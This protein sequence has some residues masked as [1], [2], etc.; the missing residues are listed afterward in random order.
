MSIVVSTFEISRKRTGFHTIKVMSKLRNS[1]KLNR[2]YF[3]SLNKFKSSLLNHRIKLKSGSHIV[4]IVVI[5]GIAN[6]FR[7][8]VKGI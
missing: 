1:E 4:V 3:P 6:R 8:T 7:L 5:I 2:I